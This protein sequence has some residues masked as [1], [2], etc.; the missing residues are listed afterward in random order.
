MLGEIHTMQ[1]QLDQAA[2]D[3]NHALSSDPQFLTPYFRLALIAVNQKPWQDAVRFTEQVTRLN[4]FAYPTAYFYNAAANYNLG[5]M[6][7]AE[8]SA[9]KFQTMDSSNHRPEAALLMGQIL[10][11]RQ[12]YQ[13]AA[14]QMRAYL[15]AAPDAA[16]AEQ[17]RSEVRRLENLAAPQPK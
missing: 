1:N 3:Y 7:L 14:Q 10:V 4:A 2:A 11:N 5:K 6:D 12:D 16:N 8:Q 17:I 9:R 15:A 13:G